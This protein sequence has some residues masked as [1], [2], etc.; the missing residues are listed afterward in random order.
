MWWL[1]I[2]RDISAVQ[3]PP[4]EQRAP[5][6]HRATKPRVP[7]PGRVVLIT[8]RCE[9][10]GR[11][12]LTKPEGCWSPR[13]SQM[14]LL[15]DS[16]SELHRWGSRS[17]RAGDTQGGTELSAFGVKA[18]GAAFPRQQ[19]WQSQCPFAEPTPAGAGKHQIWV[20]NNL[21]HTVKPVLVIP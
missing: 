9:N 7:V 8:S 16:H 15:K 12:W 1:K 10:Q 20:S 5:G 21:A 2:R 13:S 4:E 3:V 6:P 11:L 17:K 18:G 19:C 14:H